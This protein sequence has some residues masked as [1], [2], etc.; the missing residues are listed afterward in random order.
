MDVL[1]VLLPL[2]VLLAAG[3][4]VLFTNAVNSGQFEDLDDAAARILEDD[5]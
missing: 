2:S 1:I 5:T 4:L 3:F